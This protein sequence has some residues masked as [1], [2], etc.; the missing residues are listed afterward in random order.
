[1]K[2][3]GTGI[4]HFLYIIDNGC[5]ALKNFVEDV[6]DDVGDNI[7]NAFCCVIDLVKRILFTI[8]TFPIGVV[9][10]FDRRLKRFFN[11]EKALRKNWNAFYKWYQENKKV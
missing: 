7:S 6:L 2:F 3:R 1:M 4:W 5:D 11:Q 9:W 10:A 8:I